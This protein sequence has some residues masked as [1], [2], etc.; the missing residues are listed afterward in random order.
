M[1]ELFAGEAGAL[2]PWLAADARSRAGLSVYRNTVAK[3]RADA[4]SGLFPTVERLVGADWFR[5]AALAFG[6][7]APPQTPVLDDYGLDFPAWLTAFPPA[8]EMPYLAPV[9]RL[10]LAWNRAHRSVDAPVLSA[11]DVAG[12]PAAALLAA[13][14][15]PHPSLQMFWFDWTVP[16][17]W[18]AN[19]PDADPG[20]DVVWT[21]TPEGLVILRP[22]MTVGQ[23]RLS[24]SEWMFLDAC[25]NG[26]TLGE[27]AIAAMRPDPRANLSQIFA[28]LLSV[29]AFTRLEPETARP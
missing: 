9:A 14:A 10:D 15:S 17:I 16:S 11:A 25:R 1:T 7:E 2:D 21:D 13:R 3:A 26:R 29:G 4:L 18:L 12:M 23:R 24:R 22:A 20:Q 5:Q 27:A 28:A 6:G 19:R 8:R